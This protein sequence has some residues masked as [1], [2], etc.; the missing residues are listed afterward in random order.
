MVKVAWAR[1]IPLDRILQ[2]VDRVTP[3]LGEGVGA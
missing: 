3:F 2:N 1:D